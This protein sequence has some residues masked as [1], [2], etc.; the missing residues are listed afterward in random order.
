LQI[1]TKVTKG[2][3]IGLVGNTGHSF[4]D[5]LHFEVVKR[6]NEK[7]SKNYWNNWGGKKNLST[8]YN[9]EDIINNRDLNATYSYDYQ[10]G[11]NGSMT[12]KELNE[13]AKE[14]TGLI[15]IFEN[16][17]LGKLF[18]LF[19]KVFGGVAGGLTNKSGSGISS[20]GN[21]RFTTEE[22]KNNRDKIYMILRNNGFS[23]EAAIGIMANIYAESSFNTT[24]ISSDGYG[25]VGICQWTDNR[26]TNLFNFAKR[27]GKSPDDVEVQTQFLLYELKQYPNLM[28]LKNTN[29]SGLMAEQF[30]RIF[31]RPADASYR[32]SQRRGHAVDLTEPLMKLEKDAQ[33]AASDPAALKNIEESN[34]ESSNNSNKTGGPLNINPQLMKTLRSESKLNRTT[35]AFEN[36]L[37]SKI[38]SSQSNFKF[39]SNSI[40]TNMLRSNPS[41]IAQMKP[42]R[43]DLNN[44]GF[45]D[46]EIINIFKDN[47]DNFTSWT[48]SDWKKAGF[49]LVQVKFMKDNYSKKNKPQLIKSQRVKRQVFTKKPN[50]PQ[51][52]KNNTSINIQNPSDLISM[53]N[54]IPL[55]YDLSNQINT[56]GIEQKLDT[57]ILLLTEILKSSQKNNGLNES[58]IE[59]LGKALNMNNQQTNDLVKKVNQNYIPNRY[60]TQTNP[61]GIPQII[62]G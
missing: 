59:L 56:T 20:Y 40:F 10:N 54:N 38:L 57:L 52:T 31:E 13:A 25:S 4:G 49:N 15:G 1:G 29:D 43:F 34:K 17:P 14:S 24:A 53:D 7:A 50:V 19:G 55:K 44:F 35:K 2:Q 60:L 3:T 23:P 62:I 46:D 39:T 37:N 22:A 32:S 8:F 18:S 48:D 61:H 42:S 36:I 5:H 47:I 58:N 45:D 16:S 11:Q 27:L 28:A 9:P 12:N 41:K 6:P 26:K 30:C 33:A 21:G 51:I